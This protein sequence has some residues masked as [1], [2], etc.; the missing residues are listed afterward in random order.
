VAIGD[1]A[2]AAGD[3]RVRQAE[4]LP[5]AAREVRAIGELFGADRSAVLIDRDATETR[6]RD[7]APRASVLHIATH[8]V[9]DDTSPMY[10]YLALTPAGGGAEAA[11]GRLEAWEVM[12]MNLRA[13][14]AILSAC[15]TA[16][17]EIGVGEGVIGLTWS[18][19]AAGAST[20]AVSLWEVDS[21]GT[22][23]QMIEFH[24]HLARGAR[25]SQAMRQAALA[26]I[27]TPQFRHPFY[28]AA[29]SIVGLP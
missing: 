29:F 26:H 19:F 7:L 14:L 17:G 28:W 4:R 3:L 16:R 12:G 23:A 8:G 25:A 6:L 27:R 5:E 15:A 22:T 2:Q 11:D 24:R 10:S 13:D 18:L 21:A 9:L 20:A 1:P